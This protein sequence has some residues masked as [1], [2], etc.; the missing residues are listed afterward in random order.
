MTLEHEKITN[1]NSYKKQKKDLK[2]DISFRK[3]VGALNT[4]GLLTEIKYVIFTLNNSKF[5]LKKLKRGK[6]LLEEIS[7]RLS[8]SSP[9]MSA[10]I[11]NVRNELSNKILSHQDSKEKSRDTLIH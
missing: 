4:D 1:L 7:N 2:E 6:V 10:V 11:K 5:N 9:R 3:Y 8:K